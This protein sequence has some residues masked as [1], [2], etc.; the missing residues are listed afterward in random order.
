METHKRSLVK[1]LSWRIIATAVTLLVSYMWLGEW[2]SSIALALTANAIKALL[3][4]AHERG[5]NL[6]KWGRVVSTRGME[7][8]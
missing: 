6:L 5:W 3:Y 7:E 4:Y 8:N 1:T 2:G